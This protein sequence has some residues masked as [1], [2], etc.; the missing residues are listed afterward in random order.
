MYSKNLK[1]T[2]KNQ[3]EIFHISKCS[4]KEDIYENKN[5]EVEVIIVDKNDEV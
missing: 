1:Q 4:Y 2:N 5:K 3:M